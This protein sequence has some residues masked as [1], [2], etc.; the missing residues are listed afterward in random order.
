M[1]GIVYGNCRFGHH[2]RGYVLINRSFAINVLC[3][4]PNNTSPI[5]L[6]QN[7]YQESFPPSST[8]AQIACSLQTTSSS[9]APCIVARAG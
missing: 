2:D 4:I 9:P 8:A 1:F 7:R 3:I 6:L 5:R